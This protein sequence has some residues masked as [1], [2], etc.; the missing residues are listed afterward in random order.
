M[1]FFLADNSLI[2]VLA[3]LLSSAH[4]TSSGL[5]LK[6]VTSA[7]RH[8]CVRVCVRKDLGAYDRGV[9]V[10]VCVPLPQTTGHDSCIHILPTSF[11]T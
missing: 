8:F 6:S 5:P 9:C 11:L 10:Y 2:T 1:P 3:A 4:L 7:C